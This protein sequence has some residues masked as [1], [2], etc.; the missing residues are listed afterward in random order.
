MSETAAKRGPLLSSL[1]AIGG[2]VAASTCCLPLAPLLG[3]AG[4]AGASA[5]LAPLRPYLMGLAVLMLGAGFYQAYRGPQCRMRRGKLSL[6]VLWTAA[7][8]IFVLLLFPQIVAGWLA[9]RLPAG[10]PL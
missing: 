7:A 10:R 2:L 1:A 9:D 5:V 3:A 4:L 8:L 6:A